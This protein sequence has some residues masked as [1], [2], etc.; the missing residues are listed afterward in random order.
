[1]ARIWYPTWDPVFQCEKLVIQCENILSIEITCY[2]TQKRIFQRENMSSDAKMCYPPRVHV[3]Q[4]QKHSIHCK[5]C[6]NMVHQLHDLTYAVLKTSYPTQK[7]VIQGENVWSSTEHVIQR[8]NVLYNTKIC[9]L[10]QNYVIQ[11]ENVL[12]NAKVC[13]CIVL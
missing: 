11:R 8:E 4:Y 13:Y 6:E 7:R 9:Y 2:P 3:I 5:K 12:S 1:M 10:T